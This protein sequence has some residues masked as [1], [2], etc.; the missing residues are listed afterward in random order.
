M[1]L[2]RPV[3]STMVALLAAWFSRS[4]FHVKN[5]SSGSISIETN[6]SSERLSEL[7]VMVLELNNT[8]VVKEITHRV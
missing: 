8:V 3:C 7:V 1:A 2:R 6:A 4:T 5:M